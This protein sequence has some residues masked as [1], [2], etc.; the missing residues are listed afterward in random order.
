MQ[1]W[2]HNDVMP[3]Y[4]M[5]TTLFQ[6]IPDKDLPLAGEVEANLSLEVQ[7]ENP[8]F[9]FTSCVIFKQL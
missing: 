7:Y 8:S 1:A 6:E 4:L 9:Y 5:K 3:G 2:R